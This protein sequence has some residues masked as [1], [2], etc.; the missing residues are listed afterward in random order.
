M[1][2][3][4]RS[5]ARTKGSKHTTFSSDSATTILEKSSVVRTYSV[6]RY[7]EQNSFLDPYSAGRTSANER[8][9][10]FCRELD[11]ALLSSTITGESGVHLFFDHDQS[12]IRHT[13]LVV[14]LTVTYLT[15][16][17]FL[18]VNGPDQQNGRKRKYDGSEGQRGQSKQ[19]SRSMRAPHANPG[20][21]QENGSSSARPV[22]ATA[23]SQKSTALKRRLGD[24]LYKFDPAKYWACSRIGNTTTQQL[25]RKDVSRLLQ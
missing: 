10:A 19:S 18:L 23:A 7:A 9:E 12:R 15:T 13:A 16:L 24:F 6:K 8:A 14:F 25:L 22:V 3:T 1:S 17:E 21:E 4:G 2:N 5:L 11:A 20:A